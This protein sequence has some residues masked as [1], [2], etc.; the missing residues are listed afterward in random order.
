MIQAKRIC[1]TSCFCILLAAVA[2]AQ[3]TSSGTAVI[4]LSVSREQT[5]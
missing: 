3:A 1:L 4:S 2:S 5:Y